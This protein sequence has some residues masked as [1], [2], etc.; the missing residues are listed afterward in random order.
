MKHTTEEKLMIFISKV[1]E[2]IRALATNIEE[3]TNE[4]RFDLAYASKVKRDQ[5]EH[6]SNALNN[7]LK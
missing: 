5:L 3:Y 4:S 2:R 1:D 6:V 7:I